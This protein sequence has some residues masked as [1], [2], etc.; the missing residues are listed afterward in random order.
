MDIEGAEQL[1][2]AGMA[3]TLRDHLCRRI[4]LELH[5]AMLEKRGCSP[6]QV[7][8][9][10]LNC[11]YQLFRIDHSPRVTRSAAYSSFV[12]AE[13]I[14]HPLDLAA[15][16]DSWPHVLCIAPGLTI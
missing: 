13:D 15:L 8:R 6:E 11:G 16:V 7:L 3:K 12:R 14:L 2:L 4:I 5:P 10:L 1:A 9:P